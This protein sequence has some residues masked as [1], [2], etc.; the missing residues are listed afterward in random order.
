M[1]SSF[2]ST[3][4]AFRFSPLPLNG[5][6]D[7]GG[8]GGPK[9]MRCRRGVLLGATA[10]IPTPNCV[11]VRA[12]RREERALIELTGANFRGWRAAKFKRAAQ[13]VSKLIVSSLSN[14]PMN[15]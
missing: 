3:L 4:S 11:P 15:D 10:G 7:G 1:A 9:I 13:A 14:W 5:D 6:G 12:E 2:S 8:G